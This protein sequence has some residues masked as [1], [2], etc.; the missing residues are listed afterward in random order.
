MSNT[1][2]LL[3]SSWDVLWSQPKSS[4]QIFL[5]SGVYGICHKNAQWTSISR[6]QIFALGSISLS[7]LM[8]SA[9]VSI[10]LWPRQTGTWYWTEQLMYW[11]V[12]RGH[13]ALN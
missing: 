13:G 10:D 9:I 11:S 6:S 2:V 7:F 5:H 4:S 8:A 3:P 1:N 12:Y